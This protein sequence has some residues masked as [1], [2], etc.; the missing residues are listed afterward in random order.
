[1]VEVAPFLMQFAA[2]LKAGRI[3][4]EQSKLTA[5]DE[6]SS[7]LNPGLDGTDWQ[8]PRAEIQSGIA[9]LESLHSRSEWQEERL[10][11]LRRMLP[12]A[13]EAGGFHQ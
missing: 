5:S 8:S 1:M 9:A 2:E 3:V 12:T 6:S 4:T 11:S 10:Q 13:T 7:A